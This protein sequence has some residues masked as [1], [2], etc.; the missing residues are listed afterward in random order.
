[1]Y[2]NQMNS[3]QMNS[4]QMECET[5]IDTCIEHSHH[6]DEVNMYSAGTWLIKKHE[7]IR[8]YPYRCQAK[9]WTIGWGRVISERDAIKYAFTGITLDTANVWFIEDLESARN[10]VRELY[11]ELPDSQHWALT[12]LGY[13]CGFGNIPGSRLG[14]YISEKRYVDAG[15]QSMFWNN[16][17]GRTSIGLTKRR[18]FERRFW[19]STVDEAVYLELREAV[20]S[21]INGELNDPKITSDLEKLRKGIKK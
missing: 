20:K 17:N 12:S 15:R 18:N 14:K 2:V 7:S 13:N 6:I 4:V 9:K 8:L 16:V 5:N 3:V 21:R 10:K 19:N 1:M 11:P